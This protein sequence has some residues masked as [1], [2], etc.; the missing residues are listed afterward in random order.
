[1]AAIPLGPIMP[2]QMFG[3]LFQTVCACVSIVDAC[4]DNLW[5]KSRA[6]TKHER[7]LTGVM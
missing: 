7:R 1:M 6:V 5:L 4:V 2:D 3:F